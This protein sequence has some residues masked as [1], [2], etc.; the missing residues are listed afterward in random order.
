MPVERKEY[1]HGTLHS[2]QDFQPM[3]AGTL[4]KLQFIFH[5][6]GYVTSQMRL[7]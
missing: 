5:F 3:R 7:T 6:T 2:G 4:P 1:R